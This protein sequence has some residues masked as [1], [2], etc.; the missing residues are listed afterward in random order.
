MNGCFPLLQ[1]IILT[2][3]YKYGNPSSGELVSF[4]EEGFLNRIVG[5][6]LLYPAYCFFA[7]F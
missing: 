5:F 4:P 1:T 6:Y 3:V 2:D 7:F